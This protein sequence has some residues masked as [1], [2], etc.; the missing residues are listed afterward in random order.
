MVKRLIIQS[1]VVY[2]MFVILCAILLKGNIKQALLGGAVGALTIR[3]GAF[4]THII[5]G[6]LGTVGRYSMMSIVFKS[7]VGIILMLILLIVGLWVLL[8]VSAL[9]GALMTIKD[10]IEAV[11]FDRGLITS[12]E[13]TEIWDI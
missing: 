6:F 9:L 13:S 12:S 10:L 5:P 4:A 3:G 2:T 8:I 11:R 7:V 1:A